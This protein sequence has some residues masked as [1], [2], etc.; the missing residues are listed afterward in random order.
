MEQQVIMGNKRSWVLINW[1]FSEPQNHEVG[2]ALRVASHWGLERCMR[3]QGQ[4][5]PERT[6]EPATQVLQSPM[7]FFSTAAP[8]LP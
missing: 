2:L 1:V 4:A 7:V 5:D 3:Y 6:N 8:P